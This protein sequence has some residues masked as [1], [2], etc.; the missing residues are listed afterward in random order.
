[1]FRTTDPAKVL[2]WLIGTQTVWILL[3]SVGEVGVF[4]MLAGYLIV[5]EVRSYSSAGR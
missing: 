4:L 1:L 5:Y 2:R 3:T